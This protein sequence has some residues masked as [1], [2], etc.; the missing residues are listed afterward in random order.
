MLRIYKVALEMTPEVER[1]AR[2]IGE[3]NRELERQLQQSWP[4]VVLNICEGS[5]SRGGNRRL[6]YENALGSAREVFGSLEYG[7]AAGYI[8]PIDEPLRR[9]FD[10]V[11]GTLVRNVY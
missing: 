9:G 5:G 2:K 8:D 1:L 10:H 11:I 4:S 6:R 3:R 7:V